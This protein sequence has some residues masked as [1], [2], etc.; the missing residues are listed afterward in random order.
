MFSLLPANGPR[1]VAGFLSMVAILPVEPAHAASIEAI[2]DQAFGARRRKKTSYR[3]RDHVAPVASLGRVAF[4]ADVLIGSIQYWPA[5]LAKETVLLLGP[6]ALAPAFVGQGVGSCLML[7]SL[8]AARTEGWRWVFLVGDPAYYRRFGFTPAEAWGVT[9]PMEEQNRLLG[10]CLT[11][12]PP[13]AGPLLPLIT[14]RQ[15]RD[16]SP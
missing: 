11:E 15:R 4:S 5:R 12:V 1:V 3:Y 10:K 16:A 7:T 14:R 2:L 9:M 6:V 13:P 8:A